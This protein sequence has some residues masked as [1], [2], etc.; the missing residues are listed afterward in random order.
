MLIRIRPLCVDAQVREQEVLAA[1]LAFQAEGVRWAAS[2]VP[3]T[4]QQDN[5]T[6]SPGHTPTRAVATCLRCCGSSP[7]PRSVAW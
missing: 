3:A 5:M 2:S 6:V 1:P 4:V 7:S